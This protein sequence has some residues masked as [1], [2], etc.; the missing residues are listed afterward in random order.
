MAAL[1]LARMRPVIG[2]L[3]CIG[4][5]VMATV[6]VLELSGCAPKQFVLGAEITTPQGCVEARER[7]H[8]C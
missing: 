2:A 6:A 3:I 1:A 8:D 7:G 4:L 5:V